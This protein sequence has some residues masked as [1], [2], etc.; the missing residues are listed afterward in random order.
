MQV[1]LKVLVTGAKGF[2]GSNLCSY[3]EHRG[4]VVDA[5]DIDI[6]DLIDFPNLRAHFEQFKPDYV[7]HLGA[8]V[9]LSRDFAV[10]SLC[11]DPNIKGT[12][13]VLEASRLV[14][15]KRILYFSSQEIYGHG[16][17]PFS[18]KDSLKPPSVYSVTKVTGEYLCKL[19]KDL[20]ALPFTIFR[21][22]NVY[23]PNQNPARL[24]PTA[25][26]NALKNTDIRIASGSN[27][28]DYIFINDV[29]EVIHLSLH[30]NNAA[31][32]TFNIGSG[33]SHSVTDVV[34]IVVKL[35]KSA[36][37]VLINEV[38]TRVLE[39]ENLYLDVTKAEKVLNW[40]PK[41]S[42][43]DGL[44]QTILAYK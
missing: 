44:K 20:Y 27:K 40:T 21:M 17:P 19:Y 15:A 6:V 2:I 43:E 1:S 28:R 12:L 3:L 42:L 29:L 25:I 5:I 22:A 26:S 9:N 41:T 18:E 8:F 37:H 4:F 16:T 14:S 34:D 36:S 31:N 38:P 30:T 7:V 13:N 33:A 24:I 11:L 32:D 35:T 10:A 23:G 39:I